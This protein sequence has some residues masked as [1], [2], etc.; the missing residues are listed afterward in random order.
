MS[1]KVLYDANVLYPV[2]LRSFL[3]WLGVNDVVRAKWSDEILDECFENV[4][5]NNP[6]LEKA[7][8]ERTRRLMCQAIPDCVVT[9]YHGL[10]EGL[11]LPDPNDRHVLAAAISGGAEVIVTRNLRDFPEDALKPHRLV[12]QEPDTFVHSLLELEPAPILEC[13]GDEQRLYKDPPKTIPEIL[14]RLERNG[15]RESVA[16]MRK[17]MQQSED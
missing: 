13:L 8:L 14:E 12:A 17:L 7:R 2:A 5:E 11:E 4:L 6:H 3:M 16:V 15:L 10:V 1:A 9:Q